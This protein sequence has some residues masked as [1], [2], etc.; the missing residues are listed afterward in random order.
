MTNFTVVILESYVVKEISILISA[1]YKFC[2]W[3]RHNISF[4]RKWRPRAL[5]I[6]TFLKPLILLPDSSCGRNPKTKRNPNPKRVVSRRLMVLSS[7]YWPDWSKQSSHDV[8]YWSSHM[9]SDL[10][11]R[12]LN[13]VVAFR[14]VFLSQWNICL[15]LLSL[16]LLQVENEELANMW[17]SVVV[18]RLWLHVTR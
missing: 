17:E 12:P 18:W 16:L 8:N 2:Y 7:G 5:R 11:W 15:L 1:Q 13:V 14:S 10:L 9:M 6:R 3:Y 4:L